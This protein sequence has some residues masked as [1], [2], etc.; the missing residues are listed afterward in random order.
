MRGAFSSLCLNA[1]S[2][3]SGFPFSLAFRHLCLGKAVCL[4]E[5]AILSS[6]VQADI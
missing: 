6:I 5:R 4:A 1:C 3:Q 2:I